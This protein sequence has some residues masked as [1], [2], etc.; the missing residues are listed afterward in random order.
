MT[1]V[2]MVISQLWSDFEISI[3]RSMCLLYT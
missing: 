1:D 2:S 3:A